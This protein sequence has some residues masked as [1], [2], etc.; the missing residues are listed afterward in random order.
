ML[1]ALPHI[2]AHAAGMVSQG[3]SP[4]ADW[5]LWPGFTQPLLTTTAILPPGQECSLSTGAGGS[6]YCPGGVPAPAVEFEELVADIWRAATERKV[7]FVLQILQPATGP[8]Y[9]LSFGQPCEISAD[10][11]L[12]ISYD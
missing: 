2:S 3:Q 9:M 8:V 6:T 12:R 5:E 11:L 10:L 4:A 7:W 1:P